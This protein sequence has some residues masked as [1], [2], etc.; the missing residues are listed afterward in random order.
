[1][2]MSIRK[3]IWLLRWA[4]EWGLRCTD[5]W[6]YVNSTRMVGYVAESYG[7]LFI[8]V[9]VVIVDYI[10]LNGPRKN[11]SRLKKGTRVI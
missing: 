10:I 9:V 8:G 11:T 1:M 7:R 5:W 4:S 6:R 2:I 3:A